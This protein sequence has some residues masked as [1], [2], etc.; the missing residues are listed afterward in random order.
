MF[1][2]ISLYILYIYMYVLI[3][4]FISMWH[5]QY[6]TYISLILL[7]LFLLLFH[8]MVHICTHQVMWNDVDRSFSGRS[9]TAS[10][11]C[12]LAT[13]AV[14]ERNTCQSKHRISTKNSGSWRET[15]RQTQPREAQNEIHQAKQLG[16][17]SGS[18]KFGAAKDK[19]THWEVRTSIAYSWR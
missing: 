10:P 9:F 4:Y 3:D 12:G 15:S 2:Y 16:R 18:N 7:L 5:A 14:R 13:V 19:P 11:R 1:I 8:H 17:Q 6:I